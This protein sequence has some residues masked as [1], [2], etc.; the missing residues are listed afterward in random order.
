MSNRSPWKDFIRRDPCSYCGGGGGTVDHI[1][2]RSAGGGNTWEN[3]TGACEPCNRARSST[4]SMLFLARRARQR[5]RQERRA[6]L[7][8]ANGH[9]ERDRSARIK[10]LQKLAQMQPNGHFGVALEAARRAAR[11][12]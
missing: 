4:P 6:W 7:G 1:I 10:R 12:N 2:P 5:W 8:W 3:L 11:L 9:F